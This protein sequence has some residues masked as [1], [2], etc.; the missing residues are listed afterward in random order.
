MSHIP[1]LL[2]E[3][4]SFLK[5]KPGGT[6][7][8]CTVGGGGHCEAILE[9]SSPGGF[10]FGIDKD[11]SALD[12]ADRRLREKFEGRYRFFHGDYK[13]FQQ[14]IHLDKK[15]DIHGVVADLG[16]SSMQLNT[17]ERGFSFQKDGPL[18]MR[19][20]VSQPVKASD[21]VNDLPV[22]DL[23]DL[24]RTCGEERYANQIAR[25]IV[26]AREESPILTT[27][28]LAGIIK[29]NVPPVYRY[30]RIHPATRTFQ[31]IRIAVNRE[32]ESLS[33][34]IKNI[35][36]YLAPGGRLA[37]ISFHS[38]EDRIVK[39]TFLSLIQKKKKDPD[40][41]WT[42]KPVCPSEEEVE[43]NPAS[44]SAK[45]RVIERRI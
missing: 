40:F 22:K 1:V 28:G 30:G 9:H 37:V 7:I 23:A 11:Q 3:V 41:Q 33:E 20:D 2:N 15:G 14:M 27:A 16:V 31:A 21:L 17:P 18:D 13:D 5:V 4:V 8:D 29:E 24:I 44:R 42:K 10:L 43:S 25:A 36:Q 39:R 12:L 6:Y 35:F 34:F 45:L 19:M 32:L 38:L 26:R